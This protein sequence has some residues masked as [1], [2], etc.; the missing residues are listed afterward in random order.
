MKQIL[1]FLL[2]VFSFRAFAQTPG[3]LEYRDTSIIWMSFHDTLY[4]ID[5][6]SKK[7]I[8]FPEY[9][10]TGNYLKDSTFL[11]Y[12]WSTPLCI[13]SAWALNWETFETLPWHP[14]RH[15]G[16]PPV[17]FIMQGSPPQQQL[18]M[19]LRR[20]VDSLMGL[21]KPPDTLFTYRMVS[22]TLK[23]TFWNQIDNSLYVRK[24][25]KVTY[26]D[27]SVKYLDHNKKPFRP[28][29]KIWEYQ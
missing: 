3:Y 16:D 6:G 25:Y 29:Y 10:P 26:A 12:Q 28:Y 14:G 5:R 2:C 18:V 11:E 23:S 20:E 17:D 22:C 27:G 24:V 1:F 15:W 9:R 8:A 13:F 7:F 4:F 19:S 21:L